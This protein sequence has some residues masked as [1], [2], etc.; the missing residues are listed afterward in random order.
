MKSL[1][2]S[3]IKDKDNN[4]IKVV[5]SRSEVSRIAMAKAGVDLVAFGKKRASFKVSSKKKEKLVKA[6]KVLFY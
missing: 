5:L 4:K 1:K 6:E 3:K 2:S